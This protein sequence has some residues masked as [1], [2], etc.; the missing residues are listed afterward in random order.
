MAVGP[1]VLDRFAQSSLRLDHKL[2]ELQ[3][4]GLAP[5]FLAVHLPPAVGVELDP[6]PHQFDVTPAVGIVG[7]S[8]R[9]WRND[10]TAPLS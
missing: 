3:E 1:D 10:A 9:L 4:I 6:L 8:S 5:P 7:L 2:Q